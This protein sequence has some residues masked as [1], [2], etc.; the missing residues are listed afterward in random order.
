M[1]QYTPGKFGLPFANARCSACTTNV[2]FGNAPLFP[3]WSKWRWLFTTTV[4]SS[5]RIP[6]AAS[7]VTTASS[8]SITIVMF[9]FGPKVASGRSTWT[10]CR[11]VSNRMLPSGVRSSADHTGDR[12]FSSRA[13]PST[14]G[15][16]AARAMSTA[17]ERNRLS[18]IICCAHD[19]RTWREHDGADAHPPA[20]RRRG[21]PDPGARPAPRAHA[22]AMDA[23]RGAHG[24]D[25]HRLRLVA[26]HARYA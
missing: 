18:S 1:S 2:A 20:A 6:S 7:R 17:P 12:T 11:P 9:G 19:D 26:R 10:G 15:M 14:Q 4:M 22:G 25:L 24:R 13:G 3:A 16:N 23:L 21:D 8:R 5:G